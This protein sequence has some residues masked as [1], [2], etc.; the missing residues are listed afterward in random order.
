M[1]LEEKPTISELDSSTLLFTLKHRLSSGR[2]GLGD[3]DSCSPSWGWTRGT[4]YLRPKEISLT[5]SNH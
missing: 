3:S 1:D 5:R 4:Q 2:I